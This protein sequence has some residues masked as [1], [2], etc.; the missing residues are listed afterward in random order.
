MLQSRPISPAPTLAPE[1]VPPA[2]RPAESAA[3]SRARE[4]RRKAEESPADAEDMLLAAMEDP[5]PALR[6]TAVAAVA[7]EPS[8]RQMRALLDL[9]EDPDWWV[10]EEA[11]GKLAGLFGEA[12]RELLPRCLALLES[13]WPEVRSNAVLALGSVKDPAIPDA[14]VR[15]VGDPDAH[16]R[17][18]VM[19]ALSK[20]EW[21]G[22]AEI[23]SRRVD[24]PDVH[25]WVI[26]Y[27]LDALE[28]MKAADALRA[29]TDSSN[30]TVRL[31]AAARLLKLSQPDAIPLGVEI[32]NDATVDLKTRRGFV[33]MLRDAGY[34][35]E[36]PE[37]PTLLQYEVATPE[38]VGEMP[39]VYATP[40]LWMPRLCAVDLGAGK[41]YLGW[42]VTSNADAEYL[43]QRSVDGGEWEALVRARIGS[44]LDEDAPVG[45][46]VAYRVTDG[47]GA[48]S[49]V[50][51]LV[52]SGEALDAGRPA[53]VIAN[54]THTVTARVP[55]PGIGSLE[56]AIGELNGDGQFDY[57]VSQMA[58]RR[59][60]A[61][62]ATG[63]FLWERPYTK[64]ALYTHP[65]R[66]VIG[67]LEGDGRSEVVSLEDDGDR[68]WLIV[69]DGATGRVRR[70]V[71]L[72]T[73][74][75]NVWERRDKVL[76]VDRSGCGREDTIVFTHNVYGSTQAVAFDSELNL[77]WTHSSSLLGGHKAYI[78]DLNGD[79]KD[80]I[81]LG[82]DCISSATGELLWQV[83]SV[84]GSGHNDYVEA[85]EIDPARPGLEIA[86]AGCDRDNVWMLDHRGSL[87]WLTD[88]GHA[89]WLA[90]GH[91]TPGSSE[92]RIWKQG[93]SREHPSL[94]LSADGEQLGGTPVEWFVSTLDWDGDPSNGDEL[95]L[96]DGSVYQPTTGET[97]L[98][99]ERPAGLRAADVI[100][101][102]REELVSVNL[103][104]GAIEIYT[105]TT[106]NPNPQPDRWDVG[107]WRYRS[108]EKKPYGRIYVNPPT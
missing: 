77:L 32:A 6:R 34:A 39:A 44:H 48:V 88:T 102:S 26:W 47:S 18:H 85:R 93:K 37:V 21:E 69:C 43:L 17:A 95:L 64:S 83:P 33:S 61:Y 105:N 40:P 91:F 98:K 60:R 54:Q 13:Q 58:T 20:Q 90:V 30:P 27:G 19:E 36:L 28:R 5:D 108:A 41:V 81:L 94:R 15:L 92:C 87:L 106:V 29:L 31:G 7:G 23:I 45:K 65:I 3:M 79:G 35:G 38:P 22:A 103:S 2:D 104:R 74:T 76:L 25:G 100:G 99:I 67:D 14:L 51:R 55:N 8:L 16:V 62:S 84:T 71:D 4:I 73:C 53:R 42:S 75:N 82:G 49:T 12:H 68:K 46:Q 59:K 56:V 1:Q 52:P 9:C 57:V 97:L 80:E 89:Q 107:Y 24:R 70:F 96:S 101:D 78:V 63:E 11:S 50:E 72:A 86:F 10:R 66:A